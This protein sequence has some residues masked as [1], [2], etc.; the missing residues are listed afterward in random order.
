MWVW[1]GGGWG[2]GRRVSLAKHETSVV[3]MRAYLEARTHHKKWWGW[4]GG[5]RRDANTWLAQTTNCVDEQLV[6][7]GRRGDGGRMGREEREGIILLLYPHPLSPRP[8]TDNTH[9]NI[10]SITICLKKNRSCSILRNQF[11][12]RHIMGVPVFRLRENNGATLRERADCF[13]S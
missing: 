6:K 2:G 1:G 4:V 5:K 8:P 3:C 9:T 12:A 10:L 13:T 7:G 11:C